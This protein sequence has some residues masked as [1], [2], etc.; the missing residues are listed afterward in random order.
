LNLPGLTGSPIP[1]LLDFSDFCL[2]DTKTFCLTFLVAEGLAMTAYRTLLVALAAAL[3]V[4]PVCLSLAR[5]AAGDLETL[6]LHRQ[7]EE[8]LDQRLAAG[9]HV[10]GARARIINE[11]LDGRVRLGEA[12]ARFQELSGLVSGDG[13]DDLIGAYQVVTGEEAVW[14]TVILWTECELWRQ[15]HCDAPA[16][17]ARLRAEYQERF[18]HDPEPPPVPATTPPPERGPEGGRTVP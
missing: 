6:V 18:G 16:V 7:R 15:T 2:G 5:W 3:V 11:L 1:I 13:N 4:P 12:A 10:L 17:L 14:R 8:A 9:Q